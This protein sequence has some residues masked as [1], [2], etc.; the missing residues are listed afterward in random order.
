VSPVTVRAPQDSEIAGL[1]ATIQLT[2]ARIDA[3]LDSGDRRAFRVWCGKR[4]SLLARA[5]ALLADTL[6]GP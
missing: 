3:A 6:T 5:Q 1:T 2:C 4:A